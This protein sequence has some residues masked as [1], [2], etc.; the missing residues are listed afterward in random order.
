MVGAAKKRVCAAA[1]A[2]VFAL[3]SFSLFLP[4]PERIESRKES[5]LC[6]WEDG[7]VTQETFQSVLSGLVGVEGG[8]LLEREG[9]RGAIPVSRECLAAAETLLSGGLAELLSLSV[10]GLSRIERAALFAAFSNRGYY[11]DEFFAFDGER[12]FRTKR[13][14][15]SEVV[16]LYGSFSSSTLASCGAKTVY[17]RAEGEF[18]GEVLIGSQ[19]THIE[20]EEPYY[21]SGDAVYLRTPGGVR[22]VAALPGAK[23]LSVTC[24]FLDEGC[25]SACGGL[26]RLALP[27]TYRGTI[28]ALFSPRPVPETLSEIVFV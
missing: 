11:A 1:A 12:V 17:L 6:T 7:T 21:T 22:L 18:S 9:K 24:D 4:F 15:F 28:G 2:L 8:A 10:S 5:Y 26:E 20:A 3:L 27:Q 23:S 25:L 16:L 19:V 13:L 14:G